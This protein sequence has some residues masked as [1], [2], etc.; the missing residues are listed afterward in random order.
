MIQSKKQWQINTLDEAVVAT[1]QNGLGLSTMAAKILA[2]RGFTTVEAAKAWLHMDDS[3]MHDPFLL[4]GMDD[5]VFRI[6][7]ALEEG[8]KIMVYGDYDCDG[9]TSTAVMLNVL[10]DL[11]A[12]VTFKIPNRFK[13]GYGPHID[14]FQEAYDEGVRL[15]ITVDNGISAV[16]QVRFAKDLGMDIIIT[17]H[18]EPGDVLP[19]ADVILHPRVPENSYPFGELAGVG[20][21]FKLAHALYGEVPAHLF[22]YVAVG[23][24]AD[25]VPLEGENRYFVKRGLEA[26]R[27]SHKPW[28]AALCDVSSQ[29]KTRIDE[30][31][32][33]FLFGP[34]INAVGRLGEAHPAVELLMSDDAA[35]AAMLAK[36]LNDANT[37]RKDL[38]QTITEEAVAMIEASEELQNSFVLVVAG[39]NWN[40]GVVGIVASRLVEQYYKPTIVLCI[41]D[42]KGTAKGSARSIEGYH[43]YNELAK[44]RDIVPHFGGHPMAAGM[45]L[46]K[47][48]VEELRRRLHAQAVDCL[49]DEQLQQ[50]LR[51]DIP[52]TLAEITV[53][54]IEDIAKLGPFGMHFAKPIYAL[55]N[56]QIASMKKMGATQNHLKLEITDGVQSIEAVSFNNGHLADELTQGVSISFVGDVSINEW[57]GRKKPQFKVEDVQTT[58]WQLFDIRGI[59]QP[60]RWLQQVPI[61]DMQFVAFSD[62]T[63]SYYASIVEQPIHVVAEQC[64]NILTNGY[65]VLLDL[66]QNVQMLQALL[67]KKKPS[68]IY[69]HFFVQDSQYFNGMPTREQFAWFFK[70][71]KQNPQMSWKEHFPKISTQFGVP[72]E[73]LKFMTKVFFELKFV[74]IDRG[75]ISVEPMTQKSALTDAPAYKER[76]ARMELEQLLLYAPYAE[77]KDWLTAAMQ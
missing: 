39:S 40:P 77:L 73:I 63:V 70:L 9:A 74:R 50:K 29:E 20:V 55:E 45:T 43:L 32:I 7:Q 15:I 47:E 14:L 4:H 28:V 26:L 53:E 52:L 3:A 37:E 11:G 1:L 68:R 51:V 61:Q 67:S 59:R 18:H 10:Y 34:R 46:P 22:E 16:D 38:V 69:A 27:I 35:Q 30:D 31:T 5:A 54:A 48:N 56:M 57:Q 60:S 65:I 66:P 23:T 8:E 42:E 64:D 24:V 49:T 62:A 25:L 58:E 71:L 21:A 13:H 19:E 76:Q 72:Q 44:N 12:D 41:D 17:D 2:A 36:K 33:G 6:E 75:L